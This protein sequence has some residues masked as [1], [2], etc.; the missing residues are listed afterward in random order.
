MSANQGHS[1]AAHRRIVDFRGKLSGRATNL[2][3]PLLGWGTKPSSRTNV[4]A[5]AE[6]ARLK[7]PIPKGE[8]GRTNILETFGCK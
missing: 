3:Y 4:H 8:M 2:A 6:R 7:L 1:E 5:M